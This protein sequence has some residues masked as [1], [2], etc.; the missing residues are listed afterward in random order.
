MLKQ[1][2][3][4][5]LSIRFVEFHRFHRFHMW[6]TG[7]QLSSDQS[8]AGGGGGGGGGGTIKLRSEPGWIFLPVGSTCARVF[9][10]LLV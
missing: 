6:V 7:G 10:S 1:G 8:L 2:E 4:E 5:I 9:S 3:H